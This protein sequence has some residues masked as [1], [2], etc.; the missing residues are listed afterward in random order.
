[1]DNRLAKVVRPV[2][3]TQETLG[4]FFMVTVHDVVLIVSAG[5]DHRN[6]RNDTSNGVKQSPS[7]HSGHGQIAD[8]QSDRIL[9]LPE[10]VQRFHSIACFE[11]RKAQSFQHDGHYFPNRNLVFGFHPVFKNP[12]RNLGHHVVVLPDAFIQRIFSKLP[13]C[14][15]HGKAFDD[16]LV[17]LDMTTD[18]TV[19]EPATVSVFVHDTVF[20]VKPSLVDNF[21]KG[22]GHDNL[23]F[24]VDGI[25][26]ERRF[27]VKF[28]RCISKNVPDAGGKEL[29]SFLI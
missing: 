24:P 12:H 18:G 10:H 21:V 6:T 8:N 4:L 1:M 27:F 29:K 7:I 28:F 25:P 2:R 13:F 19:G 14:D 20:D 17:I 11:N 23:V 15:V 3:F 22:F 16:H 26:E 5:Q 9:V